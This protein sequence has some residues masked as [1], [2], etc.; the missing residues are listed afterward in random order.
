MRGI[1]DAAGSWGVESDG[2]HAYRVKSTIVYVAEVTQSWRNP[3]KALF[4]PGHSRQDTV[5]VE[6]PEG[7]EFLLT[8]NHFSSHPEL[9][10]LHGMDQV[11]PAR[12][13][14]PPV[15]PAS[16]PRLPRRYVDSHGVLGFGTANVYVSHA[17]VMRS[18][19]CS[20][21]LSFT[22]AR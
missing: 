15:M 8:A 21:T 3:L 12:R 18:S 7:A 13:P 20:F 19:S 17:R 22:V 11:D 6:A 4:A 14:L 9:R 5:V 16:P 10:T 1:T 2:G